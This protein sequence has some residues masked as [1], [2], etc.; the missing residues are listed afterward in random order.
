MIAMQEAE[1][2]LSCTSFSSQ[3]DSEMADAAEVVNE[4]RKV[5]GVLSFTPECH[6]FAKIEARRVQHCF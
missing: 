3:E 2:C 5:L 1:Q 4:Q 6:R